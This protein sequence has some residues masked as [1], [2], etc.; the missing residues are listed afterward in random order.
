MSRIKHDNSLFEGEI[1]I[2]A[3]SLKAIFFHYHP[4]MKVWAKEFV[5]NEP[6]VINDIVSDSFKSLWEEHQRRGLKFDNSGH[7]TTYLF[8]IVKHKS[9]DYLRKSKRIEEAESTYLMEGGPVTVTD[10]TA[11]VFKEMQGLSPENKVVLELYCANKSYAEIGDILGIDPATARQRKKRA[12][13]I[14]Q[15]NLKGHAMVPIVMLLLSNGL[16]FS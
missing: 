1:R 13:K 8:T 15:R 12:I 16:K 6:E 9:I 2:S 10:V 4:K 5:R 7:L 11:N 3:D 14:L